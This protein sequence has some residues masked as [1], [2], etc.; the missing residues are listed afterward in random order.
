LA[1]KPGS[2]F[3]SALAPAT[4]GSVWDQLPDANSFLLS[5]S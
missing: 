1:N 4:A 3:P 2:I 5:P